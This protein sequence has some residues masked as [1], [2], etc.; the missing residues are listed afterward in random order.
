MVLFLV[1]KLSSTV[2]RTDV[3]SWNMESTLHGCRRESNKQSAV[4]TKTTI[5]VY[6]A[7]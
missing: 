7:D 1:V 6:T 3:H 4:C 2:Q 5:I